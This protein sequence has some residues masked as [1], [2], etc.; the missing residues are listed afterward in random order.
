MFHSFCGSP[1]TFFFRKPYNY[2]SKSSYADFFNFFVLNLHTN[3]FVNTS[4]PYLKNCLNILPGI[5]LVILLGCL[6]LNSKSISSLRSSRMFFLITFCPRNLS[7]SPN[8]SVVIYQIKS[9]CFCF[10]LFRLIKYYCNHIRFLKTSKR[11]M[12]LGWFSKFLAKVKHKFL[13]KFHQTFL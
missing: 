11:P 12:K 13:Q 7:S 2:Y 5:I 1:L 8:N 3:S 4:I 10:S 6:P 9:P